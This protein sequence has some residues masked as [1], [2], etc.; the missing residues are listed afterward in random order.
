MANYGFATNKL[1]SMD[2]KYMNRAG[3]I[4]TAEL[5]TIPNGAFVVADNTTA[6]PAN[7]YSGKDLNL[8]NFKQFETGDKG[9][10]YILDASLTPEVTDI[11]GNTYKVGSIL[12]NLTFDPYQ[13]LKYRLLAQ[14]DRFYLFDGNVGSGSP[15]LTNCYL[16]PTNDS[17]LFTASNTAA[18]SGFCA[19]IMAILPLNNGLRNAGSQYLCKVISL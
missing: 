4:T 9:A 14:D 15:S 19:K 13:G 6:L 5:T 7:I 1:Q 8:E 17:F 11:N 10:S 3:I 18:V 2:N 16:A 12:T